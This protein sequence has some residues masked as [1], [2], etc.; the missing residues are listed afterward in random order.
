MDNNSSLQLGIAAFKAGNKEQ[1][2][3]YL[4]KAVHEE[5]NNEHA[6]GWLSN[7]AAT[8]EEKIY[9][10]Q[11]LVQINPNNTAVIKLLEET[12][13]HLQS[14][15]KPISQPPA[16]I[17]REVKTNPPSFKSLNLGIIAAL[18]II[19]SL[20]FVSIFGWWYA[21]GPCGKI[22]VK[23]SGLQLGYELQKFADASGLAEATPR[24][25]LSV[26][27]SSMQ[28]IRTE[29]EKIEVPDCMVYA[30][31]KAINLMNDAINGALAFASEQSDETVTLDFQQAL[32][33]FKNVLY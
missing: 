1:A 32:S 25:A 6:W 19:A 27:I 2:R 10:L 3:F 30:Q 7:T 4:L 17:N 8:D 28:A 24:I 13:K 23:N 33:D 5:P 18:I 26:P 16:Y 22:A 15:Q 11:Q 9:C 12:Q 21:Y 31:S 29:T 20:V 14:T